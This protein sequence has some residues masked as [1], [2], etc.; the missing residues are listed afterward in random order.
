[1]SLSELQRAKPVA[2]KTDMPDNVMIHP[3]AI[4]ET[5]AIGAGTKIWAFAHVLEG[6]RIGSDCNICDH[7]FIEA[8]VTI[9]NKVTVKCGVQLWNGL[10]IEDNVFIG[11]N[12]T[13]TN[14]IRPRS[15]AY[16]QKFSQTVLK[17]GASIGANSTIICGI[18]IGRW[19]MVG[20]G[21]V[22]T[23]DVPDFCLVYGNP[24]RIQS[25]V[26]QCSK[27][28]DFVNENAVCPCGKKYQL[29]SGKVT[30]IS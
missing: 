16:P 13:F 15:K 29:S 10:R 27:S 9:G 6:A 3:N 1:M 7:T 22:V 23:A 21:S 11:P 8:D 17:C 5:T 14:D 20:A 26:C 30:Q 12:A 4:V 2:D 25:Y 28:L 19:A 24:A 18:T